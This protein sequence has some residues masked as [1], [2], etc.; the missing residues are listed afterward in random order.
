M[1]FPSLALFPGLPTIQLSM[2]HFHHPVVHVLF[3]PSSCPC[4]IPTIQL[5]MSY[6]HHPVVHVLFPPSSCPCLIPTIQLSMSHS[7][8][9]VVHVSFPPS[10]CPCL[11]PTIQLSMSHSH[12]PVVHVSFPPSSC[13]CLIPTIQLSMNFPSLA[14]FPGLLIVYSKPCSQAFPLSSFFVLLLQQSKSIKSGQ[15]EGLGTR[16]TVSNQKLDGGQI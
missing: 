2:S 15:S 6:S 8:H 1:N 11:I 13:P 7:H 16:R 9:P 3:P 12:H 5:S 10:S 4:L 14:L